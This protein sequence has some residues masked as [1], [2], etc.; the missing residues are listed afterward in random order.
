[1]IEQKDVIVVDFDCGYQL[2]ILFRG[3]IPIE[4]MSDNGKAVLIFKSPFAAK[5]LSLVANLIENHPH[6]KDILAGTYG[7]DKYMATKKG[8]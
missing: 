6:K 7:T 2:G 3:N 5:F 8:K 1:M 4:I